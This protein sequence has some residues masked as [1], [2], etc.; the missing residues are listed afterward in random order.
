V[1][2]AFESLHS[3]FTLSR[4]LMRVLRTIVHTPAAVVRDTKRIGFAVAGS[5]ITRGERGK[6][7]DQAAALLQ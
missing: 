3:S 4:R 2:Q 6:T 5:L 7:K 1:S